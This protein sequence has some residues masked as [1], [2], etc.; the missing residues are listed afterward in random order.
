[1]AKK[2]PTYKNIR[3]G[4]TVYFINKNYLKGWDADPE[5][6]TYFLYSHKEPLPPQGC[7][8]ERMPVSLLREILKKFPSRD[9]YFSRRTA[10]RKMKEL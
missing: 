1:M 8:I 7:I 4:Q 3:Q 5:L 10:I 2:K 6:N 9:F